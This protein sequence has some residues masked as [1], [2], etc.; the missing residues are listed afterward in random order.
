M[1]YQMESTMQQENQTSGPAPSGQKQPPN[2]MAT[3]SLVM[4]ILAVVICCC[5]YGSFIF[6]GLGIL[7]AVL[8]R[9]EER[10]RGQAK[11]GL[12]LS[13]AGLVLCVVL[14]GGLI[15]LGLYGDGRFGSNPIQNLP[16]IPEV[17]RPDLDLDN[18]L[19][20]FR[21]IPMG[22]GF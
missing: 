18:I 6:G 20:I 11:A 15:A 5:Y 10:M 21:R 19:A 7:F 4:G 13:I 14:W 12:A 8:S 17:T 1:D 22:G 3:A 2:N 9:T 16:A